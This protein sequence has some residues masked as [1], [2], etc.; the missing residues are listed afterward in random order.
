MIKSVWAITPQGRIECSAQ[1]TAQQILWP[2]L[3]PHD[4][5]SIHIEWET[6][7]AWVR[8]SAYTWEAAYAGWT[9]HMLSPKLIQLQNGQ[10][11]QASQTIGVWEL[12]HAHHLVWHIQGEM[13]QPMTR[14]N[15]QGIP[16]RHHLPPPPLMAPLA[17]WLPQQAAELARSPHGFQAVVCFTD[18]CD[19]DTPEAL[20]V[21]L[22]SLRAYN[23][24]ITKGFFYYNFAKRPNTVCLAEQPH[25]AAAFKKEGH[26]A[27]WHALSLSLQP[28]NEALAQCK[29][30]VSA[31]DFT[32]YM[33][34]GHQP[35]NWSQS[36]WT[37]S[38]KAVQYAQKGW[39]QLWHYRDVGPATRHWNQLDIRRWHLAHCLPWNTLFQMAHWA[40]AL[41]FYRMHWADP[42]AYEALGRLIHQIKS[43]HARGTFSLMLGIGPTL[44]QHRK[45]FGCIK[46]AWTLRTRVPDAV[47]GQAIVYPIQLGPE[48]F[49]MFQTQLWNDW[50]TPLQPAALAAFV[51]AKGVCLAHTYLSVPLAHY[52]NRF[53]LTST[54]INPKVKPGLARLSQAI[55]QGQCWNPT[56]SEAMA[57]WQRFDQVTFTI[58]DAGVL[59]PNAMH[60]HW[61][62]VAPCN[63][64]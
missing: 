62:S 18:H 39:R 14:F 37:W 44:W 40:Q 10:M 35:Y 7:V 63:V 16:E 3:W 51:E 47:R 48:V 15:A 52:P 58:T 33:D 13:V 24:T 60:L 55:Q 30:F 22:E 17:L 2:E 36:H 57:Y 34:H 53:M 11:V 4:I 56:L 50:V 19:F 32:T 43:L 1:V 64:I 6:A 31:M 9:A 28:P 49:W 12:V 46:R 54:R 8:S 5:L 59:Q 61:R 26:E 42:I 27:A 21:Q 41:H 25:W 45:V 20:Q 23:M 38:E 29:S